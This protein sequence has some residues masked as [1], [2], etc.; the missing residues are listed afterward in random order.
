MDELEK[1]AS[2]APKRGKLDENNK[3]LKAARKLLPVYRDTIDAWATG[4]REGGE[5]K[6]S[7]KKG[8]TGCCFQLVKATL[9][10]G[11]L[12]AARLV[13]NGTFEKFRPQLEATAALADRLEKNPD[14]TLD[15]LATKTPCAFLQNDECAIY[16]VRPGGCRSYFVTSDPANCSPDRPG[17]EVEQV[18]PAGVMAVFVTELL[19][20]THP[21][22]PGMIGPFPSVVL[23][24]KEI[25]ERS[26]GSFKR[27]ASKSPLF[28]AV[29]D[30]T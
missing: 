8:C 4:I 22:V 10:E 18:D 12:V 24:G 21:A 23:V 30:S 6:V 16:D 5:L 26:T 15:Y 7:C 27:W 9:A 25:I 17:A 11:A 14:P 29:A 2:S 28:T 13:E 19:K 20:S 3:A 1:T